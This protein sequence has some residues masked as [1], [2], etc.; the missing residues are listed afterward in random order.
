MCNRQAVQGPQHL[1]VRLHFVRLRSSFSRHI[2]NQGDD[3]IHLGIDSIDLLEVFRKRFA[4]RELLVPNESRHFNCACETKRC[5]GVEGRSC[6]PGQH[7]A[8]CGQVGCHVG[9]LP[10]DG[11]AEHAKFGEHSRFAGTS[12]NLVE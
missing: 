2:W 10:F 1:A 4:C 12:L 5:I 3:R 7:I 6:D 9:T 11:N 8:T